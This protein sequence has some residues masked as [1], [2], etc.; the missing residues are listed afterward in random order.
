M[1][2]ESSTGLDVTVL[3]AVLECGQPDARKVL[4]RQLAAL[5]ADESTPQIERDQVVPI[6]LK[7]ATDTEPAVRAVLAEELMFVP[8][9]HQDILFSI[10]ADDDGVAI[11]FLR[12]TPSLNPWHM[13]AILR[14]GDDA[15]QAAVAAREDI[16]AE[17]VAYIIKSGTV[18]AALSLLANGAVKFAAADYRAL[19]ARLGQSGDLVERLL[20]VP[21]LPLDIRLMQAR[22]AAV[23]MRQLMAERGWMPANDAADLVADAEES[24]MLQVLREAAPAERSPALNFLAAQNMLTPSLIMRAACLGEMPVVAA[25]LGHLAGQ[26][27]QKV[28]ETMATRGGSGVKALVSRSGLPQ[29]CHAL[30]AAACEVFAQSRAEGVALDADAFGRRILEILMTRFGAMPPKDQARQMDFVGRFGDDKVRKIARKLKADML[31]AA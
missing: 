31:R 18:A 29:P 28:M 14:V 1:R 17:A 16:S 5:V 9:L 22:R 6:L 30:L 15:R 26:P 21:H 27:A 2:L 10:V 20:A 12:H 8:N 13:V 11:P 4:A 25:A 7:I 24:A 3:E 23:R 19:Y